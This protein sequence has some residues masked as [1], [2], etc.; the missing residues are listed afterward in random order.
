M[1]VLTGDQE[2]VIH[3]ELLLFMKLK[4]QTRRKDG[5]VGANTQ[6]LC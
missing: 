2:T 1:G 3:V 6:E 4:V 5:E